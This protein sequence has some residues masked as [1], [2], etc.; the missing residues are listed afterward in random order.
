MIMFPP[1]GPPTN[2]VCEYTTGPPT[3]FCGPDDGFHGGSVSENGALIGK[4]AI[5]DIQSGV[6]VEEV[7][8][9]SPP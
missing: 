8:E 4:I 1:F 6:L 5:S 7:I 9:E 3:E 2:A